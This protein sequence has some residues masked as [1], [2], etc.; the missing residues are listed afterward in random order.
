M[1]ETLAKLIAA[2]L[3]AVTVAEAA[4]AGELPS[5]GPYDRQVAEHVAKLADASSHI[6]LRAA[7][8]LGFLRAYRAETALVAQLA[9]PSAE[10]R[11]QAA[12]S[13]GWCGGRT[14]VA[15]LLEKLGDADWLTRQAAPCRADQPHGHGIPVQLARAG[16]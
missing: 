3:A 4:T 12:M 11:R 5:S 2:V 6:R 14:S 13:L 9:D 10:V 8:A 16:H 1:K 15:P 7:E